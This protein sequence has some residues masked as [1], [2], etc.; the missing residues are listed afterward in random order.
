MFLPPRARL[1]LCLTSRSRLIPCRACVP[2]HS[3][4]EWGGFTKAAGH[5]PVLV[6]SPLLVML[7]ERFL[8]V[9]GGCFVG[10]AGFAGFVVSHRTGSRVAGNHNNTGSKA[11][12]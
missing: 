2:V 8:P 12:Q 6:A 5:P 7:M 11:S 10:F 9:L 1:C 3:D 4:V